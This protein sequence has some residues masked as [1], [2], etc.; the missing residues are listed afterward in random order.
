MV[1]HFSSVDQLPYSNWVLEEVKQEKQIVFVVDLAYWVHRCY[2]HLSAAKAFQ[3]S[4]VFYFK[5]CC[6]FCS[7]SRCEAFTCVQCFLYTI[8]I[9]VEVL[10]IKFQD[11]PVCINTS[12]HIQLV[13][14]WKCG[15][16]DK[17][18]DTEI[19]EMEE[20]VKM[21]QYN[22]NCSPCVLPAYATLLW[23]VQKVKDFFAI[24]NFIGFFYR[25]VFDSEI[26]SCNM[27]L[28]CDI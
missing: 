20:L 26:C 25:F 13:E 24:Q 17:F 12:Q 2:H 1:L 9:Y 15:S 27:L 14:M 22:A 23:F 6:M 3:K 18:F 4:T 28:K 21:L 10:L 19:A 5:H 7:T 16:S 11:P 8:Q